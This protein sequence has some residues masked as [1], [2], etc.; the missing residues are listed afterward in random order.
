MT[1]GGPC[2]VL[3]GLLAHLPISLNTTMTSQATIEH[4]LGV[5]KASY[6]AMR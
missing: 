5:D 3:G 6:Q 1:A 4:I 2:V